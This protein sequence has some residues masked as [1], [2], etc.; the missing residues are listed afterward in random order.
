MDYVDGGVTIQVNKGGEYEWNAQFF[1]EDLT[2]EQGASYKISFDYQAD[3]AQSTSFHVMQGHDDYLPYYSGKLDW[4]TDVQHYEDTFSYTEVTDK[5]VRIGFNLGGDGMNVPFHVTVT[6]LKL[7]KMND[8]EGN[9]TPD[10][11]KNPDTPDTTEGE[12]LT[13]DAGNFT[14][15]INEEDNTAAEVTYL[16]NG[17]QIA[18]NKSGEEEWYIQDSYPDITLE[19][20]AE[21]RIS[22]DYVADK[23]VSLYYHIQQD[24]DPYGQYIYELLDYTTE[25]QHYSKTFT[26]TEKTDKRVICVFNCGGADADA[27]FTVTITNLALVKLS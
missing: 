18:V 9:A 26:M 3:S 1:Y 21:Y 6:N 15:W 2:L 17:I 16:D 13:E 19:E 27:P 11:P 10:T 25:K 14:S 8:G 22:F 20:G 4:T 5:Q 12:N 23:D 24:Y 7:I